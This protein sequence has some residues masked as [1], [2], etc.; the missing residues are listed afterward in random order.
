MT[1]FDTAP[2][3]GSREQDE[4]SEEI[5]GKGLG[6]RREDVV[7]AS[8]FGRHATERAAPHFHARRASESVEASLRRLGFDH[9]DI[10]FFHSPFSADEI[11][12]DV[13]DML[14]KLV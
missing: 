10:L 3:Y 2:I 6:K 13:W 14:S 8:K 7:V 9:L 5:L 4:I 1:F 11:A 12:D